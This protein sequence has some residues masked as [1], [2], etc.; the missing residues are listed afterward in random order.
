[1]RNG[2]ATQSQI[3]EAGKKVNIAYAETILVDIAALWV[4]LKAC[5][6]MPLAPPPRQR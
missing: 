2:P 3:Q 4:I 5:G 1:M 6:H